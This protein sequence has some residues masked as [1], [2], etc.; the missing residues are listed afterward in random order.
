MASGTVLEI[1]L[2]TGERLVFHS[3][4]KRFAIE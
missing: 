3:D 4:A 1:K 2:I